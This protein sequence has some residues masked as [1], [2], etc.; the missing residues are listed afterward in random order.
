M[1]VASRKGT[2]RAV[3]VRTAHSLTR[4]TMETAQ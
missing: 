1:E 4:A 2:P 3:A